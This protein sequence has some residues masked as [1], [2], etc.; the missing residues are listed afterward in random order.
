[1]RHDYFGNRH[2][3][4]NRIMYHGVVGKSEGRKNHQRHEWRVAV[5]TEYCNDTGY[6]SVT[7][8]MTPFMDWK[9][10]RPEVLQSACE[11][12][13]RVHAAVADE[14]NGEFPMLPRDEMGYLDAARKFLENV[15]DIKLVEK[16]LVSDVHQF[17]GQVDLVCKIK[18][19]EAE[20][21]V[22]WKTSISM[23]KS[24]GLQISAYGSLVRT[25]AYPLPPGTRYMA[26]QLRKN[27]TYIVREYTN[28]AH[29]FAIF[30]NVLSAFRYFNPKPMNF[31]MEVM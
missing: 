23:S 31:D 28:P 7:Q 6:V 5:M 26:V 11:R 20:T 18:G 9:K 22:D 14:I 16:R 25:N 21:V 30:L 13:S 10:I 29:D 17:T 2:H 15:D 1:M 4:G 12:G 24:W 3:H 27:G 19:D 8:C